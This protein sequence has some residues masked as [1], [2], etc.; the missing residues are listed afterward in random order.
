MH[1]VQPWQAKG[2]SAMGQEQGKGGG[3]N[4]P[5]GSCTNPLPPPSELASESWQLSPLELKR[6]L[7]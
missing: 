6:L 1:Q 2:G 4:G 3:E 7:R 5:F